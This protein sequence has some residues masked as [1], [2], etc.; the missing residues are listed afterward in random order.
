MAETEGGASPHRCLVADIRGC[1]VRCQIDYDTKTPYLIL[2]SPVCADEVHLNVASQSD[3]DSWF[4]ALLCWQPL[5]RKGLRNKVAKPHSAALLPRPLDK[6]RVESDPSASKESP[7]IKVGR[8]V[9]FDDSVSFGNVNLQTSKATPF[10]RIVG[11]A[12]KA[13]GARRWRRVSCTLRES[14]EFKLF[15]EMDNEVVTVV[16]LAQLRR[17]AIQRL[18]TSVL[19]SAHSIIIYPQYTS[20]NSPPGTTIAKPVTLIFDSRVIWEVWFVLLRAFTVPELYGP[21]DHGDNPEKTTPAAVHNSEDAQTRLARME[22]T[23]SIRVNDVRIAAPISPR[24]QG[25]AGGSP[26]LSSVDQPVGHYVEL[27]IDCDLRAKTSIRN[28]GLMP[29]WRQ[30]FDFPDLPAVLSSV[31]VLLKYRPPDSYQGLY[32]LPHY[33][34]AYGV[35]VHPQSTTADSGHVGV[36]RDQVVGR[37]EI[38]LG[39][40]SLRGDTERSWPLLDM[41]DQKVGE[42]SLRIKVEESVILMQEVYENLSK[43]LHKFETGLTVHMSLTIPLETKR[44]SDVLVNIFQASGRISDWLMA[45]VED[46]IDGINT[47]SALSRA[48]YGVTPPG[49]TPTDTERF[50]SREMTL[51]DMNKNAALEANLLFRGNTLL[52]K[53]LDTH[54]RRVGME[55]LVSAIGQIIHDINEAD[56]DCEVDPNRVTNANDLSR[57]WTKLIVNTE[58]VWAAISASAEDCPISLKLIFRHV[59]ACAED[60]YGDFLRSIQYSSVSGF[61]FLRFFCPAVLNPKLFG[62]LK[63]KS[64]HVI[65]ELC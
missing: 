7:I 65:D 61:L 26:N 14:G 15:T 52:T 50:N 62:L 1:E 55:Y 10:E 35:L 57:N 40:T 17:C 45:L 25:A 19:D 6:S 47:D 41:Q 48:R 46:E 8:M 54:M 63:C 21:P 22:H 33:H 53:S 58:A 24:L 43:M 56:P 60:K 30:D 20:T 16:Q 9:Y 36:F 38:T 29:S 64:R 31:T 51:R 2:T 18:E 42:V 11:Q 44:L 37:A 4:A 28:D 49:N 39:D 59:R 5:R 27:H 32:S 12:S 23:L 34:D 13:H 3:L